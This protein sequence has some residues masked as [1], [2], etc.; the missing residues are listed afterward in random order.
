VRVKKPEPTVNSLGRPY[1][2]GDIWTCAACGETGPDRDDKPLSQCPKNG[3]PGAAAHLNTYRTAGLTW[4]PLWV[5]QALDAR[6]LVARR[7]GR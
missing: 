4:T 5:R 3:R 2:P 6:A 7:G 1:A